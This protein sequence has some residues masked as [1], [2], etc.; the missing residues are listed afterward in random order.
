LPVILKKYNDPMELLTTENY[1]KGALFLDA[2]RNKIGDKNWFRGIRI[3][4][5]KFRH[6][7]VMTPDFRAVMES[8]SGKDLKP[9]FQKWL[10]NPGLPD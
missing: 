2:L 4:Y 3:Y 7:N 8:V 10:N 5:N 9:F 6:K 1:E